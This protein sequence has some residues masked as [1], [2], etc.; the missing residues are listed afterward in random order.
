MASKPTGAPAPV[1]G[2]TVA[3]AIR[4][5]F[6]ASINKGQFPFAIVGGIALLMVFRLPESE[7]VPLIHWMVDRLADNR[8]VG[9]ALFVLSVA[10]WYIHAQRM[11]REFTLQLDAMFKG[12]KQGGTKSASA[13]KGG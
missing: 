12:K 10:G 13:A 3:Q 4:D 1:K 2:I 6:I 8:L 7:I 11:R 9:Y 5:V